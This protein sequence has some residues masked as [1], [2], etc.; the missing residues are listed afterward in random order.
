M[1]AALHA[2]CDSALI[3]LNALR[4]NRASD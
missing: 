4:C 3:Q 2:D 1:N